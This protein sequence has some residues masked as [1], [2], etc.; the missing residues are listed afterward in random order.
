MPVGGVVPFTCTMV[1]FPVDGA[2]VLIYMASSVDVVSVVMLVWCDCD[3]GIVTLGSGD[4]IAVLLICGGVSIVIV[5]LI[6]S[7]D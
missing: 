1:T 2:E 6:Y 5:L 7:I 4:V 3:V